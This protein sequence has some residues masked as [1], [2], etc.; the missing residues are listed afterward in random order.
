M[1]R[2]SRLLAALPLRSLLLFLI[3]FVPLCTFFIVKFAWTEAQIELA[4]LTSARLNIAKNRLGID[5]LKDEKIKRYLAGHHVYLSL[6]T[7]PERIDYIIDI[8]SILDLS[9]VDKVFLNIP[10]SCNRSNKVYHVPDR[11][12]D[13][14]KLHV[15]RLKDD[16]GPISKVLPTLEYLDGVE[17][18]AIIVVIDDDVIYPAGTINQHIATLV[19]HPDRVSS[20]MPARLIADDSSPPFS[21]QFPVQALKFWPIKPAVM[22][23]GY[24]S[25]AFLNHSIDLSWLRK[26]IYSRVDKKNDFCLLS[27]DLLISYALSRRGTA[28]YLLDNDVLSHKSLSSHPFA[29]RKNPLHNTVGFFDQLQYFFKVKRRLYW[30]EQRLQSCSELIIY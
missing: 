10:L 2:I 13:I 25:Y 6:T 26:I 28:P 11:L 12:Y 17:K 1:I 23:H 30:T 24:G 3:F 18:G 29:S 5:I 4:D 16:L 9:H 22:V 14:K 19:Y 20:T 8:L 15:R 21:Y 27:D 7:T